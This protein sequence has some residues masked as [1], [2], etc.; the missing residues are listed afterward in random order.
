MGEALNRDMKR[1]HILK[2]K[3]GEL[4]EAEVAWIKYLEEKIRV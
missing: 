4:T 3:C 1:L 2:T